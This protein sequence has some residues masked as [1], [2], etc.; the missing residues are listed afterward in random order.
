M[1][2]DLE[3]I[4][5]LRDKINSNMPAVENSKIKNPAKEVEESLT[6]FLTRRLA[7]LS[8][9]ADF[10][11]IIKDTI[12][13]RLPEASFEQLIDLLHNVSRDN[14]ASSIPITEMFKNEQSGKTVIETLR[15]NDVSSAA[16]TLYNSTDDKNIL[17]AVTYLGQ[18]MSKYSQNNP[19]IEVKEVKEDK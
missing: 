14:T 19:P 5:K 13:Q 15:D 3:T 12:R 10:E 6:D 9:D 8:E 4:Y 11:N 7:K 18:I 17:Q 1:N 16:N 2:K